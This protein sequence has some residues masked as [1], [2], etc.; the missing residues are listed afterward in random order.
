MPVGGTNNDGDALVDMR[1][2][3]DLSYLDCVFES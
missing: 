2:Q 1:S 3:L